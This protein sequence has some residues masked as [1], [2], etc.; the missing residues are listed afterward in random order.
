MLLLL[1]LGSALP[2]ELLICFER[3][4][5]T[6][7]GSPHTC[8][9]TLLFEHLPIALGHLRVGPDLLDRATRLG[10]RHLDP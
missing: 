9:P 5:T 10:C 6:G 1:D 2:T 8:T 7:A 3:R 4:L